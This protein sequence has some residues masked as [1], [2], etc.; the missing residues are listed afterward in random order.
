MAIYSSFTSIAE[1]EF[2]TTARKNSK[3]QPWTQRN[4]MWTASRPGGLPY[5]PSALEY[6]GKDSAPQVYRWVNKA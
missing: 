2:K 6:S 1:V 5:R 4:D 3:G